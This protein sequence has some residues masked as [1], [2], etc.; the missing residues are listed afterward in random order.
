[1]RRRF[2]YYLAGVPGCNERMLGG[3]GLLDR[4]MSGA[5]LGEWCV[6]E[7]PVGPDGRGGSIAACGAH[8]PEFQPERQAWLQGGARWWVG[9]EDAQ[10]PPG[11][12]D[13]VRELGLE[14]YELELGDG[15]LWRA[16]RILRWDIE[17]LEH[18]PAIPRMLTRVPAETGGFKFAYEVPEAFKPVLKI[19]QRSFEDHVHERS[20]PIERLFEDASALLSANYRI[21]PA[22]VALLGLLDEGNA[23]QILALSFDLPTLQAHAQEMRTQGLMPCEPTPD[24]DAME[25]THG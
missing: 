23:Q 17:K 14:G 15:R 5:A 11:P 3:L 1:M 13:L 6:T 18:Q 7:A 24:S 9:L 2:L 8:P 16:P 12:D 21:G 22:E 20:V 4:F 19:A 10:L 25:V